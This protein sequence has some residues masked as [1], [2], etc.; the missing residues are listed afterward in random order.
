MTETT[1]VPSFFIDDLRSA[2]PSGS[3]PPPEAGRLHLVKGGTEVIHDGKGLPAPFHRGMVIGNLREGGASGAR[4]LRLLVSAPAEVSARLLAHSD[5]LHRIAQT[6]GMEVVRLI[7]QSISLTTQGLPILD[8]AATIRAL[9]Q[10]GVP[11]EMPIVI[12]DGY[13]GE[14]GWRRVATEAKAQAKRRRAA[15]RAFMTDPVMSACISRM[16]ERRRRSLMEHLFRHPEVTSEH[17]VYGSGRNWTP[18]ALTMFGTGLT[19]DEAVETLMVRNAVLVG[20]IRLSEGVTWNSGTLICRGTRFPESV[21]N[22]MEGM[23]LRDVV[24][25]P[26]LGDGMTVVSARMDAT[27]ALRVKARYDEID[28]S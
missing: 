6:G 7:P 10:S 20:R 15:G 11:C 2:W 3:L 27:G 23:A 28:I 16:T 13:M 1:A 26:L 4:A 22:G 8:C 5:R 17:R 21:V 12:G 19:V 25:H 18:L 9:G 24:R 14:N